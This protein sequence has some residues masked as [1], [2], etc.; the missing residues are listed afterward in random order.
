MQVEVFHRPVR[1]TGGKE[2]GQCEVT[3]VAKGERRTWVSLEEGDDAHADESVPS[4]KWS[5]PR[6]SGGDH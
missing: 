1:K 2:E 6:L 3:T 5:N 4:A